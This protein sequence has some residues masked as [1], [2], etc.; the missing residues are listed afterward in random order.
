[1]EAAKKWVQYWRNS[2]ADGDRLRID[3]DKAIAKSTFDPAYLDEGVLPEIII[4]PLFA[5]KE[6][7][8]N[9]QRK[10]PKKEG[11]IR[12]EE[13]E[14]A[15]AVFHVLPKVE[16]GILVGGTKKTA[17]YPFWI[18]ASLSREGLLMPPD[19]PFPRVI[20]TV[21]EPILSEDSNLSISSVDQVDE[22][23]AAAAWEYENWQEYWNF[24]QQ[25]FEVISGGT[26][27]N[28]RLPGYAIIHEGM[29]IT[30][31]QVRG[32]SYSIIRLYDNLRFRHKL[33]AL[34]KTFCGEGVFQKRQLL[35]SADLAIKS[36]A[37]LG[38]I[39]RTYSLYPSQRQCLHHLLALKGGEILAVSGPP[40]TGKT[41][42]LQSVIANMTVASA[43]EGKK[44]YIIVASST[45]NQAVTNIIDSFS[46]SHSKHEQLAERWLPELHTYAMYLPAARKYVHNGISY[47]KIMGGGLPD[48]MEHKAYV[49]QAKIYFLEQCHIYAQ[50]SFDGVKSAIDWLQ[51]Q[52]INTQKVIQSGIEASQQTTDI[53]KWLHE[54]DD[55]Q[56]T[57]RLFHQVLLNTGKLEIE[58]SF[59]EGL[60][61]K[62]SQNLSTNKHID[63][64][65][66]WNT[67]HRLC[68]FS[69]PKA[70]EEMIPQKEGLS[71]AFY[72]LY[73]L[74]EHKLDL[75]Y[76]VQ[77]A[78]I[79]FR[80]WQ[81]AQKYY[82]SPEHIAGYLDRSFR[83]QAFLLAT[84]YWEGRWLLE[85]EP[86]LKGDLLRRNGKRASENKWRRYA[87]LTPCFVSTFYMLPR[88][89]Q[90]TFFHEGYETA[91]LLNF[92]DLLIVDEAGQVSPEIA[93]ASFAL[94]KKA[95]VVGDIYQIQP[96]WKIPRNID[97]ANI[98]RFKLVNKTEN[99][100]EINQLF[101]KGML[102]SSGNLMKMALNTSCYNLPERLEGGLLL[103]E[104]RRCYND[105]ISYCNQL[106]YRGELIPK[107]GPSPQTFLPA[108][109]YYHITSTSQQ[110][111]G[112]RLNLQEAYEMAAWL[113]QHRQTILD[114]Y[115]DTHQTIEEIVGILTPFAAQ[116]RILR[117]IFKDYH[118]EVKKMKIGTIHSLQ[119]AERPIILFSSVYASNNQ[120][121]NFF[122]DRSVHILNVAVSRAKD[123]FLLFGDMSIFDPLAGTPSGLLAKKLLEEENNDLRKWEVAKIR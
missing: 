33:P 65:H 44:P 36:E 60:L 120:G 88:F 59:L 56:G 102:A 13:I 84:H 115:A 104:H 64:H 28:Y 118:F 55:R 114:Y 72:Q 40:G 7:Q 85:I 74:I 51:Q 111:G 75:L 91:P 34:F 29:L 82:D 17:V 116:R 21:L 12:L 87:M 43:I 73:A 69:L 2:L 11:W 4:N 121:M 52:I 81:A 57:A 15:L 89:F 54:Y 79:N 117:Q 42:F 100:L 14:I 122:F 80:L 32:A 39:S 123:S 113:S 58:I 110:A 25:F 103:Q 93:G 78:G 70:W 26:L 23:L 53:R 62:C 49:K 67:I 47:T 101:K 30:D 66:H 109:G 37:H 99:L 96:I 83:H 10:K 97:F 22:A 61:E 3:I 71:S 92:I 1:M 86:L 94:A 19:Y 27:N 35:S 76:Q 8:L 95:L 108:F 106:A 31:D 46:R 107:R 6:A 112:S 41:T 38:H 105:I 5:A 68:P 45:N 18:P 90:F 98:A 16:H 119:G 20:R 77:V 24:C 48:Q 50:Q 63:I 9:R